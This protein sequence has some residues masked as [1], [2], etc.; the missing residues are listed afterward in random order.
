MICLQVVDRNTPWE[1]G[2]V[3]VNS[4]GFGGAN[5]HVILESEPARRRARTLPSD[6]PRLVVASG[7]T[8]PA[9]AE[10]LALAG[11]R[12][13]DADLHALLDA[14]HAQNIPGHSF[15]GYR[16]L[17]SNPPQEEIAVNTALVFHFALRV[18][19]ISTDTR[20]S[21]TGSGG[22]RTAPGVVRVLGH[23]VTVGGHGS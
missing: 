12:P 5:A 14:V 4:F 22:R 2:L 9:V 10:L 18:F 1:G 16:V 15:R 21:A 11:S 6:L 17:G 20:F 8:E 19:R 23:G 13:E 7:R 3:A